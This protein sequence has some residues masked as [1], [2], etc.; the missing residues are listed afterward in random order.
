MAKIL[1]VDDVIDNIRLLSLELQ[2]QGYAALTASSGRQGLEIAAT[3]HPDVILLDVMMPDMDGIEVCRR[4]KAD[5]E[6]RMIPVILVTAMGLDENVVTGLDAGADDYVSKPYRR[7]VLAARIRAALRVKESYDAVLRTNQQLQEE[8]ASRKLAEE[9]RKESETTLQTMASAAQDAIIMINDRGQ[10]SFWN[11]SAAKIFGYAQ[12]EATGKNLHDLIVRPA[13]HEAHGRAFSTFQRTGQGAVVGKTVEVVGVRKDGQEVPVELSLSSMRREGKWHALGIVRDITERKKAADA[14]R[15][16]NA[17][18]EQIFDAATPMAVIGLDGTLLKANDNCAQFLGME[19]EVVVGRRCCDLLAGSACGTDDCCLKNVKRGDSIEHEQ[20]KYLPNDRT[21]HCLVKSQPYRNSMGDIIGCVQSITDISGLKQAEHALGESERE[22]R[23]LFESSR[24]AIMT[25]MAEEGF[26]SGNAATVELFG[27]KNEEDFCSHGP[28]DLSPERQPDGQFSGPKAQEMMAT[29]FAKG[30]HFF[31]WTHKRVDGREFFATVLLTRME[32][33]GKAM[34]QATV[35]DITERKMREAQVERLNRELVETSRRAGMAEVATGVLHNVGNVLNSVNVSA[36]IIAE[37]LNG[38][39]VARV[40][41]VAALLDEHSD[42]LMDFFVADAR[43]NQLPGYLKML[44]KHLEDEKVAVIKELDELHQ[45]VEHVK[46]IINLQQAHSR[47][48][49]VLEAVRLDEVL[50]GAIK[51]NSASFFRH[52]VK[53]VREYEEVPPLMVD[54][55]RLLQILVNLISNAKDALKEPTD[56]DKRLILRIGVESENC[57]TITV[58]DNGVGI[59]PE[60]MAKIFEHGFTTKQKGH[61]FGLH[62]SA[63]AAKE[64]GG[65]LEVDSD[66]LDRGASFRLELPLTVEEAA[67]CTA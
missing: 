20:C 38:S 37:K 32:I 23:A 39:R 57:V 30:S 17:D 61:G 41:S 42:H 29:A 7:E 60:H 1:V 13:D 27:C 35:R 65:S 66:G 46:E 15:K 31:E 51:L 36:N 33:E 55:H 48:S 12:E 50:D 45:N 11:D 4:L 47:V 52:S 21:A 63:L 26:L 62:S 5:P 19:K 34:L 43:G 8:I 59:D 16:A 25:L 6:T 40:S 10:V 64:L 24:D 54:K 53:I 3:E 44:G 14:V 22:Y 18:L 58:S 56:D 49:G 28:A 67:L 2:H 9:S